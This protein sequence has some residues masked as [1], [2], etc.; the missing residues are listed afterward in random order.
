[1]ERSIEISRSSVPEHFDKTDPLVGAIITTHDGVILGTAKQSH[2]ENRIRE[3][4]KICS[5]LT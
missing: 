4:Y 2:K 1:M 5:Q 3:K